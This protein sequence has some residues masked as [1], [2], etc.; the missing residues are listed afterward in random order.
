MVA[1]LADGVQML[2]FLGFRHQVKNGVE[3]LALVSATKSANNDN[4]ATLGGLFAKFDN[5]T[6]GLMTTKKYLHR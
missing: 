5:L 6:K 1:Q 3:S 4:F 2:Y